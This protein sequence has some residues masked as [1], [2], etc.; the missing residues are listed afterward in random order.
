MGDELSDGIGNEILRTKR[1]LVFL[2]SIGC[3]VQA[4]LVF[5]NGQTIIGVVR[6]VQINL[7]K[8]NRDEGEERQGSITRSTSIG[9]ASCCRT[10]VRFSMNPS[11]LT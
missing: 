7:T 2:E 4:R 6:V 9:S 10:K 3:R 11:P 1:F 8:D 5:G